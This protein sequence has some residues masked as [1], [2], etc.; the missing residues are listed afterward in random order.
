[1]RLKRGNVEREVEDEFH[2]VKFMKDG[3]KPM[4]EMTDPKETET[5][6]VQD[7]SLEELRQLAK[8]KG[9]KGTSSLAK[10]ELL[11]ILL[12]E[13][14]EKVLAYTN[15]TRLI[16]QLKNPARELALIAYNRMGTEGESGRSDGGES[17]SFQDM[18]DSIYSVLRQYRLARAGGKIHEN[19][20]KQ[21]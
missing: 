11:E 9:L 8:A 12:Q 6:D 17:Y 19:K 16:P 1:M 14:E 10:Q 4:E 20:A 2:A 13:A 21:T 3:Y 15:R 5:K 7:M 18:P